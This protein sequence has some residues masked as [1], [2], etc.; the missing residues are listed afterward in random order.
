M[1]WIFIS[2][3]NPILSLKSSTTLPI[4]IFKIP[5]KFMNFGHICEGWSN[6]CI[7]TVLVKRQLRVKAKLPGTH[8]N[9]PT[10]EGFY[11]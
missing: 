7:G 8:T 11:V 1:E 4:W 10:T 3:P 2:E 9:F 5:T 6:V